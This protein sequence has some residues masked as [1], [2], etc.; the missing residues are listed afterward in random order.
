VHG[1]VIGENTYVGAG[2]KIAGGIKIGNDIAIGALSF[3]NKDIAEAGVYAG[4]PAKKI[5]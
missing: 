3:I 1:T 5:K 4:I 2:S